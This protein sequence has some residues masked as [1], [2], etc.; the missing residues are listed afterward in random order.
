[1]YISTR[2]FMAFPSTSIRSSAIR[3][4]LKTAFA[5]QPSVLVEP[6]KIRKTFPETWIWD[7]L[8]DFR[9]TYYTLKLLHI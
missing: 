8:S 2:A 4:S 5:E 9:Y 1:M 3:P 7:D 6:P